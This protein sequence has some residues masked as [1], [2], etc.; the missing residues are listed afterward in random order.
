MITRRRL[1]AVRHGQTAWNALGRFQG[2]ADPPLDPTGVEQAR[3]VAADLADLVLSGGLGA[4]RPGVLS[5]DLRRAVMTAE[6]VARAIDIEFETDPA[7]REIDLGTW[8]GLNRQEALSRF[9]TEFHLWEAGAEIR[10]GGGETPAETGRRAADRIELA[11]VTGSAQVS[12]SVLGSEPAVATESPPSLIVVGHGVSLQAALEVLRSRGV[13]DFPGPAPHLQ[14]GRYFTVPVL[15]GTR[16]VGAE[17][18][19]LSY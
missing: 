3:H 16:P 15:V 8:T 12:R 5:S 9:P 19:V 11:L 13:I 17:E 2:H 10:R 18:P 4:R 14:N 1:I 7:L 6:A